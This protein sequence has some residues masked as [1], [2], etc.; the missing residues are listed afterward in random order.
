MRLATFRE[1]GQARLG[2][3]SGQWMVDLARA[4]Q[5]H[6][7]GSLSQEFPADM[8]GLLRA[9]NGLMA[10]L[11][12]RWT[13]LQPIYRVDVPD[14]AAAGVVRSLDEVQY[15]APFWRPAKSCAWV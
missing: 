10:E 8:I 2:A 1:A 11:K 6:A 5:Q 15:L 3:Q 12:S 13:G 14:L 9:G 4:R 7:L